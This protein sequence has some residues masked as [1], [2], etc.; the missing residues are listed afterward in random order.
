MADL[1]IARTRKLA[2]DIILPIVEKRRALRAQL[3]KDGASEAELKAVIK[4]DGLE[5]FARMASRDGTYYKP[6]LAQL[7]LSVAAIHTTSDLVSQVIIDLAAHPEIIPELR[8]EIVA[9]L[10]SQGWRK[11]AL[12]GLKKLDSCVRETQR[13]K[14]IMVGQ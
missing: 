9:V 2:A 6:E 4:N 3:E 13:L 12:Y 8:A 14:P 11:T 5:W 1:G 7:T 10:G